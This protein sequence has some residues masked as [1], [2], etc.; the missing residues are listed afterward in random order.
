MGVGQT[1]LKRVTYTNNIEPFLYNYSELVSA[2]DSKTSKDQILPDFR[3]I[4][5]WELFPW[6]IPN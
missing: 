5:D 4:K 6:D 2:G 1:S 3:A